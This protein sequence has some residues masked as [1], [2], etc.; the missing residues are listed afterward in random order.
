MY[1][2]V[3]VVEVLGTSPFSGDLADLSHAVTDGEFS[4][5]VL[6]SE[7]KPVTSDVMAG[8]LIAQ[9]S[10]PGFLGIEGH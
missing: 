4:G 10:E 5:A 9:G 1:R 2:T 3:L 8:L 6:A 7:A